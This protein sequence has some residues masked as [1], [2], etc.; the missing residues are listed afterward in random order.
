MEWKKWDRTW[1][2]SVEGLKKNKFERWCRQNIFPGVSSF[3]VKI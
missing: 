3:F 1:D 2:R